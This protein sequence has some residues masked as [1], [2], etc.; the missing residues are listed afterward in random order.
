MVLS[1]RVKIPKKT[2]RSNNNLNICVM[3]AMMLLIPNTQVLGL[4]DWNPAGVRILHTYKYG[5]T[6][7]GLEDSCGATPTVG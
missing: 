7:G 6:A 5:S 2:Y 1:E 3:V 4:V